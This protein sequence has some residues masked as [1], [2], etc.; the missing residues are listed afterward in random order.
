MSYELRCIEALRLISAG[1]DGLV[2]HGTVRAGGV[3]G[4]S[5]VIGLFMAA[6]EAEVKTPQ[7]DEEEEEEMSRESSAESSAPHLDAQ[8]PPVSR[9]QEGF[10]YYFLLYPHRLH[11]HIGDLKVDGALQSLMCWGREFQR[12]RAAIEKALSPQIQSL[13]MCGME[14]SWASE[15]RRLRKWCGGGACL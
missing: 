2:N 8:P 7:E 4:N 10:L 6:E 15:E 9:P 11:H 13:V 14:K 3:V 5:P 1:A 12:E